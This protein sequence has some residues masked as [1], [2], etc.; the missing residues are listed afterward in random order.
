MRLIHFWGG[1]VLLLFG[2]VA[3]KKVFI[4][5]HS[6]E[7]VPYLLNTKSLVDVAG[8]TWYLDG[9]KMVPDSKGRILISQSGE[10]RL[11]YR[12]Y[13]KGKVDSSVTSFTALP[14]EDYCNAM[15]TT[16]K[17]QIVLQLS[18]LAPRH[19]DNFERLVNEG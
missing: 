4:Q 19:S 17:G 18:S 9:A 5:P 15:L 3:S 14:P 11:S 12:L 6:P 10:H 16:P 8:G 13:F 2:C 1:L 7:A